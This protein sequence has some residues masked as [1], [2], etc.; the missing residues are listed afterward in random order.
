MKRLWPVLTL[1]LTLIA[2]LCDLNA[3][4]RELKVR[5]DQAKILKEG[6]WTY[7][8]LPKGMEQAKTSGKPLLVIFRCI[9]CEACAQLDAAVIEDNPSVRKWL[10]QFVPVRIVHTNGMDM[11]KFQF[12]YDQSW[13][14][15]VMHADGTI[16][17]RYGT[18]SHQ[19]ESD[20]DVSLEGFLDSLNVAL[21]LHKDFDRIRPQL[22]AK[23]GPEAPVARPELFP[24]LKTKYGSELDYEGKVVQSCIHCHQVGEALRDYYRLS[25][26]TVPTEVM[27]PYPNP[28]ILGLVMDPKKART[29]KTIATGSAA[30]AAGLKAGDQ[31]V[32]CEGQP[33]ISTADL[34]WVLHRIGDKQELTLEVVR[35]DKPMPIALKLPK[36]WRETE[37]ISWRATSWALRR[38]VTGGLRLES[39]SD[40]DR[41][42]LKLD[43]SAVGLRVKHVGQFNAHAAA[44]RAGFKEGDILI[45]VGDVTGLKTESQLFAALVKAYKPGQSIAVDVQRGDKR[46]ELQLPIQE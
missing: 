31:V 43:D 45:K 38:M 40:E 1:G 15:F 10:T 24:A 41:K 4:E 26:K 8:N 30:E 19:T 29:V 17:G 6:F 42:T 13:A 11:N 36:G 28:K 46:I 22:Q 37:D 3:Q 21:Q 34:Q 39:M 32:T 44:K 14:A 12:D 20:Q 25:G 27:Y 5:G 33:I 9:P 23:T 7:N 35:G 2:S 16:I 18:R